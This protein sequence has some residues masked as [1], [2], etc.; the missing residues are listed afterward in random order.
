MLQ[1]TTHPGSPLLYRQKRMC[2]LWCVCKHILNHPPG[3]WL[4]TP[5]SELSCFECL[6]SFPPLST[7][8][9]FRHILNMYSKAWRLRRKRDYHF[10][11]AQVHLHHLLP[12]THL[13]VLKTVCHRTS[14][15]NDDEH[16]VDVMCLLTSKSTNA[17]RT[18]NF[19]KFSFWMSNQPP[20]VLPN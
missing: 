4:E 3:P 9:D 5:M 14:S 7:P 20:P 18:F 11:K 15:I 19:S 2:A 1:P 16:D 6:L 8:S 12:P 13:S 17:R 10:I